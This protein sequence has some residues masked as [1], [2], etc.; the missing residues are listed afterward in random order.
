MRE[1]IGD[2][3]KMTEMTEILLLRLLLLLLNRE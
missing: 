2:G 3:M 1:M